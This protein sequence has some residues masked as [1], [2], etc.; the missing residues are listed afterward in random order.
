MTSSRRTRRSAPLVGLIVLLALGACAQSPPPRDFN[1]IQSTFATDVEGWT[2]AEPSDPVWEAPGHIV[3]VDAAGGWQYA[4]APEKYHGD[5]TGANAVRFR[6][7]ADPDPAAYPVRMMISGDE[8]T[9]YREFDLDVLIAG[10]WAALSASL[11]AGQW[12]HFASEDSQGP[13]ATQGELDAT[14][15]A[16]SDFRLRLDL[17]S[18][19]S[20]DEVNALDDVVVE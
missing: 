10:D 19:S 2:T 20:G 7:L 12:R 11:L 18:K 1:P 8:H 15:S 6:V 3:I 14:L 9:L 17:T 13:V 16:V 4:I 5:W